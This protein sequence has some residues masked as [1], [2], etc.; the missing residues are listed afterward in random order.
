MQRNHETNSVHSLQKKKKQ[1]Q[2]KEEIFNH[3]TGRVITLTP[4]FDKDIRKEQWTFYINKILNEILD[5]FIKNH[6]KSDN[7]SSVSLAYCIFKPINVIYHITRL[8]WESHKTLTINIE[9]TFDKVHSSIVMKNKETQKGK[10][11]PWIIRVFTKSSTKAKFTGERLNALSLKT[12]HRH[13]S[14]TISIQNCQVL[15]ITILQEK[16]VK[17]I[18]KMHKRNK[19]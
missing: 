6:V 10:E 8:N 7:T 14:F 1:R 5:N 12:T 2:R 18:H 3:L 19:K 16:Q 11:L 4:I 15:I 17:V 9:M 13:A